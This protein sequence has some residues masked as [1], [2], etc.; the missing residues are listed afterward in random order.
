MHDTLTSA[1]SKALNHAHERITNHVRRA[2]TA[3]QALS[4]IVP[5]HI[6]ETLRRQ[7]DA[8]LDT[9]ERQITTETGREYLA[10]LYEIADIGVETV[11]V[12][13]HGD[14]VDWTRS[15]NRDLAAQ[16]FAL[17]VADVGAVALDVEVADE[18]AEIA[19]TLQDEVAA[20]PRAVN[21][22][23]MRRWA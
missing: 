22:L 10:G 16:V 15:P 8:E 4:G 23:I 1:E 5:A 20:I 17:V 7:C 9:L 2:D 21:A 14:P 3:A 6:R 18:A 19:H 11:P 13:W 12:V